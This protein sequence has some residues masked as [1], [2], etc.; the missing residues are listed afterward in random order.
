MEDTNFFRYLKENTDDNAYKFALEYLSSKYSVMYVSNF[1]EKS[2]ENKL[3]ALTE[4]VKR[5]KEKTDKTPKFTS[6]FNA[7]ILL[8]DEM[9]N[10]LGISHNDT[11]NRP[12]LTRLIAKYIKDNNLLMQDDKRHINI[13]SN[14]ASNLKNLLKVPD[15]KMLSFFSL[16]LYLKNHI[17]TNQLR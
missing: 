7:P 14:E 12:E 16:Q 11:M 8:S 6:G 13:H 10:F 1:K 9:Y 17:R 2:F 4:R 5:E 15:D 3:A